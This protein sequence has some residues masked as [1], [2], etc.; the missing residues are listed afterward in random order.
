MRKFTSLITLML[1]AVATLHAQTAD[2]PFTITQPGEEPVLYYIY[3]GRDGNGGKGSYVFEN[4]T[5]WGATVEEVQISLADPRYPLEQFWYFVK[6]DDGNIKIVSALDNKII[7]VANTNDAA[8]C[9]K[10]LSEDNITTEFCTWILDCTNGYYAFQTSD[11]RSFLSHNGNWSTAGSRM[12]LYNANGSADEGSR[13][14][15]EPAPT[16][17]TSNIGNIYDSKEEVIFD[18]TGRRIKQITVPGIYIING[19]KVIR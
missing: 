14:F 2:Y 18:I 7:T 13:V 4:R 12:G 5:P 16:G 15:F 10:V 6:A 17:V 11:K 3:S 8:K 1:V 19:K 9:T